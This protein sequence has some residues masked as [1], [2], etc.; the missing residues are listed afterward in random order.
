MH[1]LILSANTGEGHNSAAR[2]LQEHFEALGDRCTVRDGLA[3]MGRSSNAIIQKGHVFLY[4]RLPKVYGVG[5]R[6]E[7]KQAHRQ[8]YH[9]KLDA[10]TRRHHH[11]SKSKRA[12]RA[13]LNSGNYDAVICTHVFAARLV[14]ELRCSGRAQ[15]PSFFLATDYACSPGVN[16]L[17]VD[18][19]LIPHRALIPEF[20]N[21]GIPE[22]RLIPAGIPV[23]TAFRSR[24][25]KREARKML[26]LPENRRIA[27]FSC[28]SMGAGPMGRVV[29][30]LL[31]ELPDD[32]LL[33]AICGSNHALEHSLRAAVQSEKLQV[34]GFTEHMDAYMDAADLFLTKSGGLS[35]TEA[36]NKRV[37]MLLIDAVPGVESRNMEFM[38]SLGCA[39]GANSM[40]T[41]TRGV[42]NA[43]DSPELLNALAESCVREFDGNAAER[44]C[45]IVRER[46]GEGQSRNPSEKN[47]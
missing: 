27:V 2:A 35:V 15:I 38:I 10:Q 11:L 29:L 43:F 40:A 14:S 8:R 26:G 33:V 23:R 21:Y 7:E 4:R 47:G 5:Y 18:A 17:D 9:Q 41:L 13:L 31:S 12:L 1:I 34:L 20:A 42:A 37:P 16:Q 32:A 19:W 36:A 6:I 45:A 39:L 46:C 3:Y 30:N 28:G 24:R 25:D 22:D 44:I